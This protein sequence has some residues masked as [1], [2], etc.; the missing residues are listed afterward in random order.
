MGIFRTFGALSIEIHAK[1]FQAAEHRVN[2]NH[3]K[4]HRFTHSNG[5][6]HQ[7]IRLL[8]L[9]TQAPNNLM[10]AVNGH[11][12]SVLTGPAAGPHL[13]LHY[14]LNLK[15][16]IQMEALLLKPFPFSFSSSN[17]LTFLFCGYYPLDS[18]AHEMLKVWSSISNLK[19]SKGSN[20]WVK[21]VKGL[22][23]EPR[24]IWNFSSLISILL[25]FHCCH[26]ADAIWS[27]VSDSLSPM[28][29]LAPVGHHIQE[30]LLH[31][32]NLMNLSLNSKDFKIGDCARVLPKNFLLS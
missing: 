13:N 30:H 18:H 14:H 19:L 20:C 32:P 15:I 21:F 23:Q 3:L 11:S 29:Y 26:S 27:L 16:S 2:K 7:P 31:A 1:T 6:F 22:Y 5:S 10:D 4:S 28:V 24:I 25:Q 17:P 9:L 12:N 8:M